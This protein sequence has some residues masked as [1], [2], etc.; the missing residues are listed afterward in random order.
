M[1]VHTLTTVTQAAVWPDLFGRIE[2]I[3]APDPRPDADLLTVCTEFRRANVALGATS[4]TDEQ[5]LDA[6]W[7]ARQ[8]VAER[9]MT[10]RPTTDAGR[11]AKAGVGVTILNEVA[12][13]QRDSEVMLALAAFRAEAFA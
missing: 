10:I 13:W 7:E 6:A 5:A 1:A 2:E 12:P 11:R 8:R 9:L 3:A 4:S